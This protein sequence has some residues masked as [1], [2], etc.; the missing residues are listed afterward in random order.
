MDAMRIHVMTQSA[1]RGKAYIIESSSEPV[2]CVGESDEPKFLGW[3]IFIDKFCR[4][5]MVRPDVMIFELDGDYDLVIRPAKQQVESTQ[6]SILDIA[7][8]LRDSIASLNTNVK[9]ALD[10]VLERSVMTNERLEKISRIQG[11]LYNLREAI[12][13]WKRKADNPAR[14]L[15]DSEK[16]VSDWKE[17]CTRM[18]THFE[19]KLAE[20][21]LEFRNA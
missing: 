10:G 21:E 8:T 13:A 14:E 20:K 9:S 19:Q 2:M 15:K 16:C 5:N 6:Y 17:F 11:Q 4:L 12:E 1:Q 18:A 3:K 7:A